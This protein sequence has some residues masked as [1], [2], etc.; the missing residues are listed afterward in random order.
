MCVGHCGPDWSKL[1]TGGATRAV[2]LCRSLLGDQSGRLFLAMNTGCSPMSGA[3]YNVVFSGGRHLRPPSPAYLNQLIG[4][5]QV[6]QV[7]D[8]FLGTAVVMTTTRPVSSLKFGG[9][10]RFACLNVRSSLN[11]FDDIVELRR[12][13]H[14]DVLCLTETWHDSD[15][16]VLGRLRSAG[17]TSS[18]DRS[19]TSQT[20][21]ICPSTILAWPSSPPPRLAVT[22]QYRRCL[23]YTSPSPRDRT[24]SR[25]PSSA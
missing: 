8:V 10:L 24:R 12:N 5:L 2:Q 15:S 21:A 19:H 17:L 3:A 11:K 22:G 14:V 1:Q 16:A 25:M 18:I 4:S 7:L 13:H 9:W 23:L 6:L 20:S